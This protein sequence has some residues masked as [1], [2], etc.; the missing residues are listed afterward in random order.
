[1][2]DIR[3]R[4]FCG[5]GHLGI[6]PFADSALRR[7]GAKALCIISL[8]ESI[9]IIG[10]CCFAGCSRLSEVNLAEGLREVHEEALIGSSLVE[11]RLSPGVQFIHGS[12]FV[13]LVVQ[14]DRHSRYLVKDL[15]L[16][17]VENPIHHSFF[18]IL[19]QIKLSSVELIRLFSVVPHL[20]PIASDFSYISFLY[21]E[22]F[23]ETFVIH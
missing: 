17:P 23:A 5:C 19:D 7:P 8:L 18:V 1:L 12:S 9:E 4:F 21:V 16:S 15:C 22:Y 2:K 3:A 13:K 10:P 11:L 20:V 6:F 14:A